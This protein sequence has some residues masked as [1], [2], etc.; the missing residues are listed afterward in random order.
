LRVNEKDIASHSQSWQFIF[1]ELL[2]ISA[3]DFGEMPAI[4]DC[5]VRALFGV[6]AIIR[7]GRKLEI[8]YPMTFF[9]LVGSG[10]WGW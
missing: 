9:F 4:A 2:F 5:L 3:G 10:P 1:G 7:V 8:F 6:M